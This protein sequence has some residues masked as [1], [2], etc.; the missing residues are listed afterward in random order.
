MNQLKLN[1]CLTSI[2]TGMVLS[3]GSA[4]SAYAADHQVKITPPGQ[5]RW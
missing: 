3:F 4:M 5:P 2:L 1:T